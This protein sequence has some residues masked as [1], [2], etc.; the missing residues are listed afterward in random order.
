MTRGAKAAST[1]EGESI[2]KIGSRRDVCSPTGRQVSSGENGTTDLN[3]SA[4]VREECRPP[5]SCRPR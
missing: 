2:L 5:F 3:V 4:E 1:D